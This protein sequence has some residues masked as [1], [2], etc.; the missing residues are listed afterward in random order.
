MSYLQYF[1]IPELDRRFLKVWLR[2]KDVF[3][4]NVKLN[5]L[6][7]FLEPILYLLAMG[8]GLGAFIDDIDGV[9]YAQFIA[10][11][12]IAVSV[13][14]AS[15]FECTYSSYVRMYYQKTFDAIIATPLII[16]DVIA[17]ELFWG[18][19]RSA[20]NALVMIPVIAAF[21]LI[22]LK[23]A[24]LIVPFAFLAGLLFACIGMCFTALTPNITV[25][26]YPTLLFIT[27]MFL[28]S[29][30]FFPLKVLPEAIQYFAF[31]FLPLTHIVRI[32]RALAYGSLEVSLI[33]SLLWILM[34]SLLFF[35]L[36]MNLMKKKLIV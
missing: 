5:F 25:L 12:L 14:Y 33:S 26:E 28:F 11:A 27:P 8:F 4:K 18:A 6:P 23:Y 7:P 31:A 21:G 13:M 35:V 29:G 17:G 16:E 32:I 3:M 1:Q 15:F 10:P 22:D 34:A 20:I 30:T 9:S 19:T 24:L 36:S 2:N